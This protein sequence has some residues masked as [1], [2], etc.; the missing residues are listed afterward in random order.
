MWFWLSHKAN[1]MLN[2]LSIKT[3][4][5]FTPR[6]VTFV[7]LAGETLPKVKQKTFKINS[8]LACL[9]YPVYVISIQTFYS[10]ERFIKLRYYL[11]YIR[12]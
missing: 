9:G 5:I 1:N 12:C 4:Q 11:R 6:H 2:E 3:L 8:S 10:C 7:T